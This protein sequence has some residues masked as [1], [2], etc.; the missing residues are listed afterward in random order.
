MKV[1]VRLCAAATLMFAASA[2]A[3]AQKAPSRA[4]GVAR[5]LIK[6]EKDLQSAQRQVQVSLDSL[7]ALVD[8]QEAQRTARYRV[9]AN[10]VKKTDKAY[11]STRK[12]A[13]RA[14]SQR[15]RYLK[16]WD[17]DSAKIQNESLRQANEARRAELEPIISR[18]R[19]SMG[20]AE[21]AFAPFS[22][23]LRD[24][25]LFLGNNLSA[26]GISTVQG[27][28]LE[29]AQH[30]AQVSTELARASEAVR[31]LADKLRPGGTGR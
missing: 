4:E 7:S 27:M 2:P 19:D 10:E 20:T 25:K 9:F 8:A 22:Q 13:L 15:E 1:L 11:K 3:L 17:K 23:G 21:Q 16:Q 24:I 30:G 29:S 31:E 6:F 14:K 18:I 26:T 28:K 5:T 12:Q